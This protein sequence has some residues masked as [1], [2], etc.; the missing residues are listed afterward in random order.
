MILGHSL[1]VVWGQAR[2]AETEVYTVNNQSQKTKNKD[3]M[4]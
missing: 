3:Q 1:E 2:E 4:S